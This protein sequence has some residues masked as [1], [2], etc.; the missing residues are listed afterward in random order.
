ME[1]LAAITTA[2]RDIPVF[3]PD[4]FRPLERRDA[5]KLSH[6]Y[7]DSEIMEGLRERNA[8]VIQF[9]YRKYFRQIRSF[10][11]ANSGT[12]MDAEDVFQDALVVI[13][14]KSISG[15]LVLSSTLN[16]FL[17]SI[18]KNLWRQQLHKRGLLPEHHESIEADRLA[19]THTPELFQEEAEKLRLFS[20]HFDK[21]SEPDQ[22]F[23]KMVLNKEPL[24]R[25]AS[26][27]GYKS[28]AY[29]KARKYIIKEKLKN[30]ILSDPKYR[31]IF[32]PAEA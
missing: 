4:A 31:E 19:D 17:Y 3:L 32:N 9:V 24:S 29:A 10:V 25:I 5:K 7:S 21:L 13:Y 30:S 11:E 2:T 14:Q 16:T 18:C 12:R 8:A 15:S 26:V 6:E 20:K 28:Y 22:K 27:M 1:S 23:L